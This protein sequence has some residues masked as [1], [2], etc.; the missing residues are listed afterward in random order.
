MSH[1]SEPDW[2]GRNALGA[3]Q[4]HYDSAYALKHIFFCRL[5]H[6]STVECYQLLCILVCSP[7]FTLCDLYAYTVLCSWQ[8]PAISRCFQEHFLNDM[9]NKQRIILHCNG[10]VLG[11]V[12]T[13]ARHIAVPSSCLRKL[14]SMS[15]SCLLIL[16]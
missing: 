12:I 15:R 16:I 14:G 10:T 8:V 3:V 9:Q 11:R 5:I 7:Q 6:I 1:F 13:A 2:L 4:L